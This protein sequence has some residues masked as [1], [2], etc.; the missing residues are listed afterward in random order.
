MFWTGMAVGM[1]VAFLFG[2]TMMVI[3]TR[4]SKRE[5]NVQ[6]ELQVFW[7]TSLAQQREQIEAIR[8]L[9]NRITLA[10]LKLIFDHHF[11]PPF[12]PEG[13]VTAKFVGRNDDLSITICRRDVQI[14]KHGEVTGA[15]TCLVNEATD[16]TDKTRE[17]KKPKPGPMPGGGYA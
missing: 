11:A 2:M 8:R 7:M 9:G 4:T 17:A 6:K 14:N 13:M 16:G 3:V 1:V 15:G 10:K 5:Q 12:L